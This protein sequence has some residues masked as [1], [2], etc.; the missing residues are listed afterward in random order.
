MSG[1]K[2]NT[3]GWDV[4]IVGAGMGGSALAYS[5]ALGGRK[6]LVLERGEA[7]IDRTAAQADTLDPEARVRAGHWP[8]RISGTVDASNILFFPALG[9]GSGGSTLHYGAALERLQRDDFE[10]TEQGDRRAPSWP[11][12]YDEMMPYYRAAEERFRARGSADP[13]QDDADGLREPPPLSPCD[14]HFLESFRT[15]GMHPYQLHTAGDAASDCEDKMNAAEAFLEPALRTGNVFLLSRCTVERIEADDQR[16]TGLLCSSEGRQFHIHANT[17]VL[18]AGALS[19]PVLM[20]N[21]ANAHWP[22][23]VAN[24]SG[25]VGRNLM[26]HF[27]DFI[28]VWPRGRFRVS[29]PGKSIGFRDFYSYKGRKLG[30]IQSTGFTAGRGNVLH[31]LRQKVDRSRIRSLKLVRPLLRIPALVGS[32]L[33]GKATIFASILEDY[34]YWENRVVPGSVTPCGIHFHYTI[35]DELS[36]RTSSFRRLYREAFAGHRI[37]VLESGLNYGHA[38]G[39]CRFGNDPATSVLDSNNRSH[40]LPNLFIV[41]SSFFPSSGGTNPSLTIA[42]NALRVGALVAATSGSHHPT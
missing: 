41:D 4:V 14:R 11:I 13:L 24:S 23:G 22:N 19:S 26:F 39:T 37:A 1:G 33:F 8:H 12:S 32:W 6:V 27:S 17:Y 3:D 2:L 21:S 29:A 16:V 9:C 20:L 40:D 30:Q 15:N 28:A 25:L 35:H 34:P 38:C 18:A 10:G 42:A 31:F 5:L 7:A 36:E